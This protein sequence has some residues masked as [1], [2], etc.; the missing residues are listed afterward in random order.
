M[1]ILCAILIIFIQFNFV[2]SQTDNCDTLEEEGPEIPTVIE[3]P[4]RPTIDPTFDPPIGDGTSNR[5]VFFGHGHGGTDASWRAAEKIS[6]TKIEHSNGQYINDMIS[7]PA[8]K[9]KTATPTF[10]TTETLEF[11]G[12]E[13]NIFIHDES[14]LKHGQTLL[15]SKEN[16]CISHSMGGLVSRRAAF[17][18]SN[19]S[20]VDGFRAGG[21]VTVGTPHHGAQ[22]ASNI[23]E[24]DP[25]S[26]TINQSTVLTNFITDAANSLSAGPIAAEI[27]D[28]FFIRLLDKFTNVFEEDGLVDDLVNQFSSQ[29]TGFVPLF[30]LTAIDLR[31]EDISIEILQN[32]SLPTVNVAF[33]GVERRDLTLW[34]LIFWGMNSPNNPPQRL[35][36]DSELIYFEA[37]NDEIA[38]EI[39]NDNLARYEMEHD[40]RKARADR[41]QGKIEEFCNKFP[42]KFLVCKEAVSNRNLHRN[43][44][45]GFLIGINW[46]MKSTEL[47]DF[48]NGARTV[49]EVT[50]PVCICSTNEPEPVDYLSGN[51]QP[52]N[53]GDICELVNNGYMEVYK[54]NDGVVLAESAVD[55]PGAI[56]ISELSTRSNHFQMR[57][58]QS[59]KD[60]LLELYEKGGEPTLEFFAL[61][62]F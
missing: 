27:A 43:A 16:Y 58:D 2:F 32:S 17:E 44:Q 31:K 61:D 10:G 52:N 38:V 9:M 25:N 50:D 19:N 36:D 48:L 59:T 49:V 1:K 33:Y 62:S 45:I 57:N 3:D 5:I 34:R 24:I 4:V 15:E 35:L 30:D 8:R 20:N 21:I 37:G 41:A 6:S 29:V 28:N 26:S 11:Y 54:P 40:D 39:F 55:F 56:Y 53:I 23:I 46:W 51:C 22:L 42:P 14:K 13:V 60:M 18:G 7:F 47:W 12:S